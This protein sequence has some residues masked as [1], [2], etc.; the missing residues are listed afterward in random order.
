MD[1]TGCCGSSSELFCKRRD[2]FLRCQKNIAEGRKRIIGNFITM[3][4]ISKY[5]PCEYF[6][7]LINLRYSGHIFK[8]FV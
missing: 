1:F 2:V 6:T 8:Y 4:N 7:Y 3:T 5:D